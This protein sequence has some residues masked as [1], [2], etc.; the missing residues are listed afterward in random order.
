[1]GW[2]QAGEEVDPNDLRNLISLCRSCHQRKTGAIE[3]LLFAGKLAEFIYAMKDFIPFERFESALL[4]YRISPERKIIV[5]K[6]WT[7]EKNNKGKTIIATRG[8]KHWKSRLSETQVMEI[9]A[10]R[11]EPRRALATEFH[12]SARYISS[13]IC[14]RKWSWIERPYLAK[15]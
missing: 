9:I 3:Y 11:T 14:G 5:A 1:M 8:E 4:L 15:R 6:C 10:R 2:K 13:L 7:R 12:T